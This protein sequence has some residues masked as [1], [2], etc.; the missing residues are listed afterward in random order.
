MKKKYFVDFDFSNFWDEG[1]YARQNYI[2]EAPSDELIQSIEKELGYKLPAAYI[3]LMKL[4]N[5]GIPLKTCYP[6]Q[7]PTSW[8]EDHVAISGIMGIGRKKTYSLCGELGSQF[9]LDEWGY[10]AIGV[11][12]CDCPSAGHDVIML[13][14]RKCGRDGEPEVVHVDQE[15]DYKIT[16]VAKDFETFIKGLVDDS[17][18]I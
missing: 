14:Y 13:D 5:G 6:T 7:S 18:F 12:I 9:M 15:L 11:V 2:E 16:F 3:E 10:P 17:V 1:E 8:S 4:H